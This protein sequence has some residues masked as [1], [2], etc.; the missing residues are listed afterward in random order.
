MTPLLG[1]ATSAASSKVNVTP[2][3]E[4]A[5]A[6][7]MSSVDCPFGPTRSTSKS[8]ENGWLSP[9]SRAVTLKTSLVIPETR[10][11][12]GYGLLTPGPLRE[13]SATGKAAALVKL[14]GGRITEV[15]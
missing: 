1:R 5:P 8:L 15:V 13:A 12:E 6:S 11:V 9:L 2:A 7:D 4:P 10:I 14:T 3:R